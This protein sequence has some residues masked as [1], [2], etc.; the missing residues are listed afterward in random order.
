LRN[1]VLAP[2]LG[3]NYADALAGGRL[4]LT[5]DDTAARLAIAYYDHRFPIAL[6]DY[7]AHDLAPVLGRVRCPVAVM[8]GDR[9]AIVKRMKEE[10]AHFAAQLKSTEF[11]EAGMAFMQKRK[12]DF[13]KLG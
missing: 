11:Q 12:P 1:K 3:E 10:G 7:A 4:Q 13:S 8:T 5:Y 9:D 6:A 2:F